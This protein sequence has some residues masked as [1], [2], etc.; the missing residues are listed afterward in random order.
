MSMRRLRLS[1]MMRMGGRG[2]ERRTEKW[3]NEVKNGTVHYE[4]PNGPD[5]RC[6]NA[7]APSEE[8]KEK[9]RRERWNVAPSASEK[10]YAP[11]LGDGA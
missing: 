10:K 6:H 9:H 2:S 8:R 7:F 4:H 1:L 3:Q 5:E 11:L